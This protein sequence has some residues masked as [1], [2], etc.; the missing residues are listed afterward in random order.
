MP[1][2]PLGSVSVVYS[3]QIKKQFFQERSK[4]LLNISSKVGDMMN[5]MI[6][7]VWSCLDTMEYQ[8]KKKKEIPSDGLEDWMTTIY[9]SVCI[10]RDNMDRD[11][12]LFF[13]E[14]N[15]Y[16]MISEGGYYHGNWNNFSVFTEIL[17]YRKN[18]LEICQGV[19]YNGVI[20][21]VMHLPHRA[22][23]GFYYGTRN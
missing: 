21:V 13:N 10:K 12:L 1:T 7:D 4:N 18:P 19:Y 14:N 3:K 2:L 9:E 8:L 5:S 20:M 17:F 22:K 11:I 16:Y 15:Q 6:T 23:G